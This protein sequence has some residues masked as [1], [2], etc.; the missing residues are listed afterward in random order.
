MAERPR[1]GL[2]RPLPRD[3]DPALAAPA[4]PDVADLTDPEVWQL[5][6]DCLDRGL[7][8]HAHEVFEQRWR[9]CA[10]DHRPA[11]RAA[12]QWGAAETHAARGND[13]GA[14]RLARR[15]LETLDAAAA[16]PSGFDAQRLTRSCDAIAAPSD[17][18]RP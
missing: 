11:W 1:D 7:P 3:S 17:D 10:A 12:A 13:V 14:A 15:S 8:F 6:L 5:A 2:G 4:V 16:I 9:T 18:H